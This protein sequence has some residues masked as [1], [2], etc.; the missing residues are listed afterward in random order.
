MTTTVTSRRRV[1]RYS[2][3]GSLALF[4]GP[5][6]LV[7]VVLRIWPVIQGGYV[8][9]TRWD[10]IRPPVFNGLENFERMLADPVLATALGNTSKILLLAPLWIVG[11]LL[12][13]SVI[14]ERIPG[15]QILAS[16]AHVRADAAG[17][18]D[19]GREV[20]RIGETPRGVLERHDRVGVGGHG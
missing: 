1:R 11:P 3:L 12:L 10:G 19:D 14:Q 8:A 20:Q 5:A 16:P 17:R 6:L 7:I 2:S 4:L 15:V 13:A 18:R 9:L